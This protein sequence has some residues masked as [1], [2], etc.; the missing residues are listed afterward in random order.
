M[1]PP[2]Q[3]PGPPG[4]LSHD[5]LRNLG[6]SLFRRAWFY[7]AACTGLERMLGQRP[8][9]PTAVLCRHTLILRVADAA[10]S[11]SH[12]YAAPRA[13]F[14][15][16]YRNQVISSH[17]L[18]CQSAQTYN[19]S[20]TQFPV[21][22]VS[23]FSRLPRQRV[24]TGPLKIE[25]LTPASHLSSSGIWFPASWGR[26]SLPDCMHAGDCFQRRLFYPALTLS[27]K[28]L[29][30]LN[31]MEMVLRSIC[32]TWIKQCPQVS[33]KDERWIK[34]STPL[35]AVGQHGRQ[36]L[37]TKSVTPVLV[38]SCCHHMS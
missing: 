2:V 16:D 1:V 9:Q 22:R 11:S 6:A 21:G 30:F 10:L 34:A 7:Q 8:P 18:D 5:V 15:K 3:D 4:R 37:Q 26:Q 33:S 13:S 12:L 32:R 38:C 35:N 24:Q 25:K 14:H 17:E 27:L 29:A 31:T 20:C 28:L 23:G 19:A 36:C